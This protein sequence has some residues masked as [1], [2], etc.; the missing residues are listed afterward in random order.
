MPDWE[1]QPLLSSTVPQF[2]TS[3]EGGNVIA[4]SPIDAPI[5]VVDP[6]ISDFILYGVFNG[7]FA[8]G[9]RNGVG[10]EINDDNPLPDWTGPTQVSGGAI[11]ASWVAD[12]SS[13]SGYNLRFTINPGA[14]GDEAYF[15]QVVPIGGDRSA[16]LWDELLVAFYRVTASGGAPRGTWDIQYLK[17]DGTTTGSATASFQTL[18]A[19]TTLYWN[20][21]GALVPTDAAYLRLRLGVRRNTMAATDTATVDLVNVRVLKFA[22]QHFLNDITTASNTPGSLW[23]AADVTYLSNSTSTSLGA[24]ANY[25]YVATNEVGTQAGNVASTLLNSAGFAV[26]TVPLLI[27]EQAAPGTPAS[28]YYAIYAKTDGIL[29]GKND[30]GTESPLSPI[31]TTFTPAFSWAV[32][33]TSSWT[34]T[35][36]EGTYSRIGNVVFFTLHILIN[37]LTKG[38]ASGRLRVNLPITVGGTAGGIG[39]LMAGYTKAGY[40]MAAFVPIVG[41]AYG[42]VAVSG[43]GNAEDYLD[44]ADTYVGGGVMRIR[45]S[46][47]YHV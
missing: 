37:T 5:S 18:S 20:N 14:A 11:T 33:G 3:D 9:P 19:D 25:L 30:S 47:L 4:G 32:V 22:G 34:F 2:G 26:V 10:S 42:E 17:A 45:V 38:T 1:D 29:Y 21:P 31:T 39:C 15:E 41:Q 40:T 44:A 6:R 23:K 35:T 43:S 12:S 46:G 28:G 24:T 27:N 16:R 8:R 7:A 36:Q 13:P